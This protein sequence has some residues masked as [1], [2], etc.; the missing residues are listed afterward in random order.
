VSGFGQLLYDYMDELGDKI[1][2][3]E[4]YKKQDSDP[5]CTYNQRL[6]G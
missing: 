2:L 3:I 6:Y 5:I 1:S 4:A